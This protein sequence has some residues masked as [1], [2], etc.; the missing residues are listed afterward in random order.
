[1]CC[2]ICEQEV[3]QTQDGQ[4]ICEG[5]WQ[6]DPQGDFVPETPEDF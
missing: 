5:C 3:P 2:Q 6:E 4:S 1:M